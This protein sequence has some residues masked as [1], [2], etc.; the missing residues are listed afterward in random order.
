MIGWVEVM[1]ESIII[2]IGKGIT[3]DKY[4]IGDMIKYIADFTDLETVVQIELQSLLTLA[5]IF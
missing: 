1:P 5:R 2:F 4:I 3:K